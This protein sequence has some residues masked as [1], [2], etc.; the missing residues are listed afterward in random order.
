M[1]VRFYLFVVRAVWTFRCTDLDQSRTDN[2]NRYCRKTPWLLLWASNT[3]PIQNSIGS[4]SSCELTTPNEPSTYSNVADELENGHCSESDVETSNAA[5]LCISG[6]LLQLLLLMYRDPSE[7]ALLHL[8]THR[9]E[10]GAAPIPLPDSQPLTPPRINV[11]LLCQNLT[12]LLK[13]Q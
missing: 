11:Q 2:R 6:L 13:F 1:D 4:T 8:C 5:S 9:L 7:R 3:R 10:A 12:V